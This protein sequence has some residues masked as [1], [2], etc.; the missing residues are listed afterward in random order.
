LSLI[1]RGIK[2]TVPHKCPVCNG[3]GL[4]PN[5]FYLAI[6]ANNL[7]TSSVEPEQCRSCKGTG[8]V[9]NYFES[10]NKDK[11]NIQYDLGYVKPP[12]ITPSTGDPLPPS[13]PTI[14]GE[15][16]KPSGHGE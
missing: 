3:T 1:L 6:G 9:W 13:N 7:T 8:I 11:Y 12:M 15:S 16:E 14:C 10:L 2:M 4:V 5:G